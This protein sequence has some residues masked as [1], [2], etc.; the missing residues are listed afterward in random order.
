MKRYPLLKAL[1]KDFSIY[2]E[3]YLKG[4]GIQLKPPANFEGGS[5]SAQ[6]SFK[7]EKQLSGIIKNLEKIRNTSDEIFRLL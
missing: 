3:K 1:E 2:T 5:Y 7:S 4:S 6:F